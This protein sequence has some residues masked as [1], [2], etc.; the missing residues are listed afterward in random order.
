MRFRV[1][2]IAGFGAG[3]YL[4]AMSGRE[5]YEQINRVV[6]KV[7]R[8]DAY[9]MA[10]DKA[11]AVVDLGVERARDMV[12]SK[13]GHNEGESAPDTGNGARVEGTATADLTTQPFVPHSPTL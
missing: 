11:K 5:R 8:S 7:R 10:T 12:E 6:R 1:G 2:L 3:Y 13:L 9:D 4:G